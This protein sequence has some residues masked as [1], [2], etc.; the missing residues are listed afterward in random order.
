MQTVVC[1]APTAVVLSVVA[2]RLVLSEEE[3]LRSR[4][5][6]RTVDQQRF[7][8]AHGLKRLLISQCVGI[9]AP[10]LSFDVTSHGKPFLKD[11]DLHFN[12]SHA[13]DFVTVALD[14]SAP[15]GVDVEINRDIVTWREVM[16]AVLSAQDDPLPPLQ[17]WTAKEALLKASGTGFFTDARGL[18]VKALGN[19][20][21]GSSGE[22]L[23]DG[24][25]YAPCS[26]HLIAVAGGSGE[27]AWHV[28]RAID[29]LDA[30]LNRL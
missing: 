12:I 1:A 6:L 30:L 18:S 4:S 15:V 10:F 3:N 27:Y 2:N 7:I 5:F 29:E 21:R 23:V 20:F 26:N 13:G 22:F 8:A 24:A 28:T 17:L 16:P 25:W 19:A 11:Q 9:A 14:K